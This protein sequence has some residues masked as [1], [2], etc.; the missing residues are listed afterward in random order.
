VQSPP[1]DLTGSADETRQE[2][3]TGLM[4]RHPS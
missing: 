4:D 3:V 2:P 1:P